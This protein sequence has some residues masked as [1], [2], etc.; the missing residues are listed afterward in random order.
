VKK[1]ANKINF[2]FLYGT[3][4][5]LISGCSDEYKLV[6]IGTYLCDKL[7]MATIVFDEADNQTFYYR[8]H[9]ESDK[10]TYTMQTYT[11]YIIDSPKFHKVKIISDGKDSFKIKINN[12]I[13]VF[14]QFSTVPTIIVNSD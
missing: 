7:P 14:K 8:N 10:G 13:Y 5:I 3:L 11:T 4:I 9:N 2:L 6:L 12:E 1:I